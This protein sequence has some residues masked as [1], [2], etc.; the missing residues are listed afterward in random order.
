MTARPRPDIGIALRDLPDPPGTP[1]ALVDALSGQQIRSVHL[2]SLT[3]VS[4]PLE[5]SALDDLRVGLAGAGVVAAV[6]IGGVNARHPERVAQVAALGNGDPVRGWQ[7][8]IIASAVAGVSSLHFTVG[9][10]A[11]RFDRTT[12]WGDQ[13]AASHAV[14]RQLVPTARDVGIRLVLK[15]HEEMTT[16]ECVRLVEDTDPEVVRIGYSPVNVLARLGD[17]VAAA[18][19]VAPYVQ[20]LFLDD[21]TVS[22]TRTGLVR[23]TAAIGEGSVDWASILGIVDASV[24]VVLDLHRAELDMPFYRSDWIADHPDMTSAELLTL[25]GAAV[26]RTGPADLDRRR[27]VGLDVLRRLRLG[28]WPASD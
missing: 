22:W 23:D 11:D 24:P 26:P 27:A 7:R 19:R 8:V 21:A 3:W 16:T 13:L 9:L 5:R 10:E 14:V 15:T 28:A 17:P 12:P 6:G 2:P 1:A 20:T 4:P 18:A 25:A